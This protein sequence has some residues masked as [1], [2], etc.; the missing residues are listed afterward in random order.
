MSTTCYANSFN[1]SNID[2]ICETQKYAYIN[3]LNW[4]DS[5]RSVLCSRLSAYN[6]D[7]Q[8]PAYAVGDKHGGSKAAEK[9]EEI[10]HA[11]AADIG[12]HIPASWSTSTI[13]RYIEAARDRGARRAAKR[14]AQGG[15]LAIN[16]AVPNSALAIAPVPSSAPSGPTDASATG[17]SN[18]DD[19]S[20]AEL[21]TQ[22]CLLCFVHWCKVP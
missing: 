13:S 9:L 6:D 17:L 8:H 16:A 10:W 12:N 5:A 21:E 1:N 20:M 3:M 4:A 7:K 2:S 14:A 22:V 11:H 18:E 19:F 15:A